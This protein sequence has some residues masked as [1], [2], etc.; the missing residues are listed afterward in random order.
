MRVRVRV[1]D[2]AVAFYHVLAHVDLGADAANLYRPEYVSQ[3]R[4]RGGAD[5]EAFA[6]AVAAL[7]L[8]R[9]SRPWPTA[10]QS[11]PLARRARQA[12][13]KALGRDRFEAFEEAALLAWRAHLSE[14]RVGRMDEIRA[15]AE[16]CRVEVAAL[17]ETVA[18][19]LFPDRPP[20]VVLVPCSSLVD[21]AR[22]CREDRTQIV[23][24]EAT[25]PPPRVRTPLQVL[26]EVCH[27][28]TD[29]VV[30]AHVGK[31]AFAASSTAACDPGSKTHRLREDAALVA[32]RASLEAHGEWRDRY[33]AWS[34]QRLANGDRAATER[35]LS[36]AR[37]PEEVRGA[38]VRRR[39][40]LG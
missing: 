38:L 40:A 34:A 9:R 26:H 6:K 36:G 10:L 35:I 32:G 1:D 3:F 20:D 39:L 31:D 33:V 24:C 14:E 28:A 8:D 15:E 22:A 7:D 30:A 19:R 11:A 4:D 2:E 12:A 23:A 37:L 17:L 25:E 21:A 5:G 13:K 18:A 16:R 29:D 27:V